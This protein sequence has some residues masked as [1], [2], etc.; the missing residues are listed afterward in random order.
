[1][2]S[3][4]EDHEPEREPQ[5][6]PSPGSA[7]GARVDLGEREPEPAPEPG[8]SR[9]PRRTP[10]SPASFWRRLGAYL[11]DAV[12]VFLATTVALELVLGGQPPTDVDPLAPGAL[13]V[14]WPYYAVNGAVAWLYFAG[15]ESSQLQAT[16]GK[17]LLGLEVTDEQADP[18][19]FLRATGRYL[20][21]LASALPLGLGFLMIFSSE[22]NQALHDHLASCLV[23][24]RQPEH[25]RGR[26]LED[27][28][29]G[30]EP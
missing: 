3:S 16:V 26:N 13:D 25:A 29:P 11:L 23:L 22:R 5:T 28:G 14:L 30:W 10:G 1:M 8:P 12:V 19:S 4:L 20:G 17:H 9:E 6:P 2:T 7:I 18:I 15:M 27:P 21:K 24:E